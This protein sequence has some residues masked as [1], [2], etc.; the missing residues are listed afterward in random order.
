VKTGVQVIYNYLKIL[1]SGFRRNEENWD[2]QTFYEIIKFIY[3]Q[4]WYSHFENYKDSVF[5]VRSV[6]NSFYE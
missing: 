3:F 4:F 5:S 6:V 1:D 2:F